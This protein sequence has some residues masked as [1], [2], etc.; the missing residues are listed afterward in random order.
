MTGPEAYAEEAA[1]RRRLRPQPVTREPEPE[2]TLAILVRDY[3]AGR[4]LGNDGAALK[5]IQQVSG[6]HDC[7]CGLVSG[8]AA[9]AHGIPH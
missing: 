9:A 1:A 6:T 7:Q 4:V 2:G 3:D 8:K 5:Q